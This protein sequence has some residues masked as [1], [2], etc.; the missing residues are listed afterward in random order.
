[1]G[2]KNCFALALF[3]FD[4]L[5]NK[6]ELVIL[7]DPV[8]SFDTNKKYGIMHYLFKGEKSLK[9]KTVLMF[10]HDIEPIINFYKRI[11]LFQ[12]MLLHIVY[13]IIII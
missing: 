4:C 12:I 10:S 11:G 13:Q 7:D 5:A 8:S 3:L 1:M 9:D 6:P 2:R